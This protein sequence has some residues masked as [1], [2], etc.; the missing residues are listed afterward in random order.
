MRPCTTPASR[1]PSAF[2]ALDR[3]WAH[4]CR[5]HRRSTVVARWGR[6]EPALAGCRG[7]DDVIPP[8][9]VERTP[10]F[11]ALTRLTAV[12]DELA[13]RALLQLLV[14]GL[15]T[16]AYRL[17]QSLGACERADAEVITTAWVHLARMRTGTLRCTNAAYLL[18]SVQRDV[19]DSRRQARWAHDVLLKD[20]DD[21]PSSPAL[22]SAEDSAFAGRLAPEPLEAAVRRGALSRAGADVVWLCAVGGHSVPAVAA[23]VGTTTTAVYRLR[24]RTHE[25]LRHLLAS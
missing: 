20:P 6:R 16:L 25:R 19:L 17:Q 4:L 13:A 23:R 5:R 9:G 22:P 21:M 10:V 3:D 24:H 1:T 7:L 12:G 14:P 11:Q 18:R 8:P 15:V 2:T